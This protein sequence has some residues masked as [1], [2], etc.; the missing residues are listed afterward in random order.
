MMVFNE[1]IANLGESS[2]G[3]VIGSYILIVLYIIAMGIN[4]WMCVFIG[5]T[6]PK[7]AT[8]QIQRIDCLVTCLSQIGTIAEILGSIDKHNIKL[9]CTIATG[10][11]VITCLQPI[12]SCLFLAIIP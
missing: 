6:H 5:K 2:Q 8:Y 7:T 10:L 4:Y 1:T 12:V 11:N 9:I 3:F